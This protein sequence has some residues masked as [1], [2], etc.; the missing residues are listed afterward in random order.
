[1]AIY[2]YFLIR[3]LQYLHMYKLS[4]IDFQICTVNKYWESRL[5]G[6][7]SFRLRD[8]S[9]N[10]FAVFVQSRVATCMPA[11]ALLADVHLFV[12]VDGKFEHFKK[13][14]GKSY[15]DEVDE[16]QRK[17]YFRHNHR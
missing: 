2:F 7:S 4:I 11:N 17:T 1:M 13:H 8:M 16:G 14:H 6:C 15:Q 3:G 5:E 10:K 9:I 12:Q